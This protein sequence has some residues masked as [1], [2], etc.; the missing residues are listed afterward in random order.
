MTS[1]RVVVTGI[2]AI[3]SVGIG[4]DKF[5]DGIVNGRSGIRKVESIPEEYRSACKIAGEIPDYDPSQYMD[6]KAIR[7][8]DRFIQF[9]LSASHMAVED[10]KLDTSKENPERVGVVVGSAAGGFQTIEDQYRVLTTRGP[11]RCSPFTVPM[12]IVNMAAGWVSMVHNAKG[13]NLCQVTACA[14]S[15]HS[16]GDAFRLIQRGD[17]DVMF[18]GG[19]EAPITSLVMAG[20][21]AAR[22]LSTRNDEPERASRPFDKDRDGFVMGEGGAVLI[23]ESL[24]HAL[25]RGAHIYAEVAGYGLT[26]DAH[27]IVAPCADGDG[28]I[29]AMRQAISEAMVEP[30]EVDYVNAHGTSTPLGDRA[31]TVALKQVFQDHAKSGK[32]LISSSKSM[33]GHLLGAAGAIEAAVAIMSIEHSIVPPTINLDNPDPECDLNYVPHKAIRNRSVKVAMSNSFGFG[34]HNGSLLFKKYQS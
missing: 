29:R 4:K 5:W 20:F 3:S 11:D 30:Q 28:A 9:A 17:A 2:G 18:A 26:G 15:T 25:G 23:L 31:E 22:T 19:S 16:I 10:A 14:T 7:R 1:E 32:L 21:A 24:T 8:T 33:T 34:G 27:D 12:L 13:P 6:K